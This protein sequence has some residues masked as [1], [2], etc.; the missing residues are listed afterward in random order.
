MRR[1]PSEC[2]DRWRWTTYRQSVVTRKPSLQSLRLR[3]IHRVGFA[4]NVQ[5]VCCLEELSRVTIDEV[6]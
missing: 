6:D 2:V 4:L 3:H 5:D 1:L